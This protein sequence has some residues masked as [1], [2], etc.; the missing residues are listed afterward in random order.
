[1]S[2]R[3]QATV[4]G[5]PSL[6]HNDAQWFGNFT[7]DA[8]QVHHA[9]AHPDQRTI[10]MSTRLNYTVTPALPFEFYGQPFVATGTYSN[11]REFRATPRAAAHADRF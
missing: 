6:D 2:S 3:C 7:D 8:R 10:A 4:G 5:Y 11:I 1:M 9:F